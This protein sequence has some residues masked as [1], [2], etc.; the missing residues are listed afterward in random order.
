MA[1]PPQESGRKFP[2]RVLGV[3][4][5]AK[6]ENSDRYLRGLG[7]YGGCR[8]EVSRG[9]AGSR[10][11]EGAQVAI[12]VNLSVRKEPCLYPNGIT[13]ESPGLCAAL[14]RVEHPHSSLPR[15]GCVSPHPARPLTQPL[16]GRAIWLDEPGVAATRQP[17]ALVR[18]PFG[19]NRARVLAA[20]LTS[21]ATR[22]SA[23]F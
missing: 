16:W 7:T 23:P 2:F 10:V 13:S 4:T 18:N 8:E 20:Q 22:H 19:V 3:K 1:D 21:Y 9:A 12:G 6:T 15:R 5:A 14:P 17:R 11:D